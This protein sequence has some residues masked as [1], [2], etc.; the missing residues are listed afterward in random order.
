MIKPG[1][2]S[3]HDQDFI[4][5]NCGRL[6]PQEIAKKIQRH[7][8]TVCNYI[9][10][11]YVPPT[12]EPPPT[13]P[14]HVSHAE[15]VTIRQ[16]L[17][18]SERWKRLKMELTR[19]EISYFEEEFIKWMSQFKNNVL[20]SEEAQ[21]FDIIKLDLLKS[22]NMIERKRAREQISALEAQQEKLVKSTG[23]E[24]AAWDDATRETM[25]IIENQLQVLRGAEQ[26]KTTEFTKLQERCD[27]LMENL[28][29]TRGQRIKEIESN[30]D[31]F[32]G[33]LK[34]LQQKDIADRE[35]RMTGL[36]KL[37]AD[38]EYNRLG[39]LHEFEDGNVDRPILSADTVDLEESEDGE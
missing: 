15:R 28:K 35:G 21:V 18:S 1:R 37:A 33:L 29:A 34:Q 20:P 5:A 4:L 17:L 3:K 2:L 6:T 31:T 27:K 30:T 19:D 36:T 16:E 26:S 39:Q 22:R 11:H 10:D 14:N 24:V 23:S 12:N 8:N 9:R 38:K 25:N 13:N 32:I 7:Q